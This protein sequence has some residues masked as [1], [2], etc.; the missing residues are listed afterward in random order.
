MGSIRGNQGG[1]KGGG[2][3][4]RW[5]ALTFLGG[6]RGKGPMWLCQCE[7]GATRPV[8]ARALLGPHGLSH[9]CGCYNR[10]S[11][12]KH[13]A[14]GTDLYSIWAN[15]KG[16][17]C[18]KNDAAYHKYGG[19]GI[20]MCQRWQDSFEAFRDD[21]GPRPSRRYSVDRKDNNGHYEPGNCRWATRTEQGRNTRTNRLA[22]F[23]GETR[24]VKEW[25]E[26]LGVSY[27]A[28]LKRMEAGLT[29]EEAVTR[30]FRAYKRRV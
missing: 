1:V 29:F 15:I 22:T 13:G 6:G 23:K 21:M 25:A 16:R 7:C 18:N 30:P 11:K 9:S 24:C 28:V 4:Q 19:R 12:R 20:Q 5:T 10:D 17:C 27:H 3:Y 14:F 8:R 26:V 2:K